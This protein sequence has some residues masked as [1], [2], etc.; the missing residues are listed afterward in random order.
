MKEFQVP[1]TDDRG[2]IDMAFNKKKVTE[3]KDWLTKYEV[4]IIE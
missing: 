3:R 1:D 4:C 2:L